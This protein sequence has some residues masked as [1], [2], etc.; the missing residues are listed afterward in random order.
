L[1]FAKRLRLFC[2]LHLSQPPV[3]RLVY[4]AI[5]K[6]PVRTIVELGI[7]LGQRALRM[8][9]VAGM[10]VP[11]NEIRY[12]GIDQFEAR[13]ADD[14]PGMTLKDAHRMLHATGARIRLLPGDPFSALI[15]S[16]NALGETDLV[17]ISAGLDRHSATRAWSYLPRILHKRS[18]VMVEQ[19]TEK[20]GGLAMRL[21][22][23]ANVQ[24]MA[25]SANRKAA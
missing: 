22:S 2:L 11:V 7:G 17:V 12:T 25:E 21:L 24:R 5:H 8:I 16:A 3:D 4:Q 18:M 14:G 13:T 10:H 23:A 1:T 6:R 9:E 19:S 20:G 15:R